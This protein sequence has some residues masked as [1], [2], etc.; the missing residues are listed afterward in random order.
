MPRREPM[1]IVSLIASATEIVSALGLGDRLLTK[2]AAE[3]R[4]RHGLPYA[5]CFAA[6]LAHQRKATLAT[7]DKDFLVMNRVLRILWTTEA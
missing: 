6:G 1:R 5:D 7:A 4:A 3:F 2:L